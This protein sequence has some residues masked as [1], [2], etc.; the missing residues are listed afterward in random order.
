MLLVGL[1]L[2]ALTVGGC[3][4]HVRTSPP[5]PGP[6]AA[7][8]GQPTPGQ[9]GGC[10]ASYVDPDP[11]R[12][13]VSLRFDLAPDRRSVTGTE[14][15]VFVPDLPTPELVF[16]L[17]PNGPEGGRTK[18]SLTVSRAAAA[19]SGPF[20]TDSA[21][22]RRDTQ[23]TLLTIPLAAPLPV[24]RPV[25]ADLAFVLRLPPPTFDRMGSD[26][27]VAWWGSA[28]PMLAWERGVGWD[29]SPASPLPGETASS[30]AARTEVTVTAPATDT[31]VGPGHAA[32]P[33]HAE[34][35]RRAW[36]FDAPTVRDVA[37][38]AG[39]LSRA[40]ASV[41][42]GSGP[43]TQVVVSAAP[44]EAAEAAPL[45]A[46]GRRA[47]PLLAQ[48]F[49]PVPFPV[50]HLVA[51]P[52][53]FPSAIEYPGVAFFFPEKP[54]AWRPFAVHE[55]AHQWFYALVGNSQARDPWLDEAFATYAE[56]LVDGAR[57]A[58]R[59]PLTEGGPVGG[60]MTS[61]GQ[62]YGAYRDAVYRKGSTALATARTRAGAAAFDAAL[63]CYVRREAWRIS[64]PAAV[65]S[66]LAGLPQAVATLREAGALG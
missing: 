20:R 38:A 11:D 6:Q 40:S 13:V 28:H 35:G 53:V 41:A 10:P 1:L 61:F 8:V 36:Q 12:P 32:A 62:D 9:R 18:A 44:D 15:V 23:G 42:A 65:G 52:G 57:P 2:P 39:R 66:A 31:V 45:L 29:R 3:S 34:G 58:W 63:R 7:G 21:G 43:P 4:S 5:P 30:E 46:E 59:R 16:R 54:D 56:I 26:G 22:G 60:S 51:L 55:I 48:A 17:W 14:H 33:V 50:I 47:V 27:T 19:G 24:G 49:G 25:T 64:T 37:I